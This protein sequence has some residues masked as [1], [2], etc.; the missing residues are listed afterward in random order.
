MIVSDGVMV[1][2]KIV[3]FYL[4]LVLLDICIKGEIDGIE[5]VEWIKFFYFIFIVYFI[6][7]FDGEILEWV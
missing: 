2:K 1:L 5:V 6:V 4:D 7:F 3:E